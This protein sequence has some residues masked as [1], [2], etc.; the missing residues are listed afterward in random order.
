MNQQNK[1]EQGTGYLTV[2]V[3]TAGGVIPLEGATVNIRGEEAAD[4]G[5]LYSLRTDRA[6]QT[7]RVALVTPD[8]SLSASPGKGTPYTAYHVDVLKEGYVPLFFHQVPIFPGII[9]IQPAVMVPE[10]AREGE[11]R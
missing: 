8:P 7:D 4:S 10:T 3:S 2:K 5:I 1:T 6:G 11:Y 9:S